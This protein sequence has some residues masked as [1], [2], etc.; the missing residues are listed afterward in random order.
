MKTAVL[1]IG[2]LTG[3]VSAQSAM[4]SLNARSLD[5]DPTTAEAYFDT[6]LNI[7]WLADANYS[8]TSQYS[9]TGLFD[10]FQA[11]AWANSLEFVVSGVPVSDWRLP[12]AQSNVIT[13]ELM[14]LFQTTLGNVPPNVLNFGPF[15]NWQQGNYWAASGAHGFSAQF[16]VAFDDG[17]RS[18]LMYATAVHAG[19]VGSAITSVPEPAS[20]L[21]ILGG[22]AFLALRRW[23]RER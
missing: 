14:S 19:D 20:A 16:G 1:I 23:C 4:A 17:N 8:V 18:R 5:Q 13:T 9:Q 11:D 12:T 10:F 7:T 3:V 22:S 6:E 21:L 2:L 15:V